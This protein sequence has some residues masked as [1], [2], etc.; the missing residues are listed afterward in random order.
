MDPAWLITALY[1]LFGFISIMVMKGVNVSVSAIPEQERIDYLLY[2]PTPSYLFWSRRRPAKRDDV[3]R[4]VGRMTATLPILIA[5][6][7]SLHALDSIHQISWPVRGYLSVAP[8]VILVE[9]VSAMIRLACLPFFG[10][11]PPLYDKPH[12]SHSLGDFW[13]HRWSPAAGGWFREVVFNPLR[14]RPTMAAFAA[15]IASGLWHEVMVSLPLWLAF[16][17]NIFGVW[18]IYFVIQAGGLAVER[19]IPRRFVTRR[20]M[21]LWATL[22]VPVPLALNKASILVLHF[23]PPT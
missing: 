21:L 22:L 12:Q 7:W 5:T 20:R 14:R 23:F 6:Y 4:L 17:E 9:C 19:R 18:T 3:L 10:L 1:V 16:E 11:L 15:F 13:G 8:L 2:A